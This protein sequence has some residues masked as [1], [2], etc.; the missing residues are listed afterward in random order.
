ML[1]MMLVMVLL[2]S[3]NLSLARREN[4]LLFPNASL[5][6]PLIRL[7]RVGALLVM[8]VRIF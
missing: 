7:G 3:L 8:M 4:G 2:L 1:L 6:L 5:H